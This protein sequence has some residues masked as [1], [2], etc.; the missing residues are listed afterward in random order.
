MVVEVV[1]QLVQ[2]TRER[3]NE[4]PGGCIQVINVKVLVR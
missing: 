1:I 2:I 3:I 4:L